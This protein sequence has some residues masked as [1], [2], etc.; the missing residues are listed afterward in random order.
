MNGDGTRHLGLFGATTVGVG[1]IVGGGIL[2]LAGIAFATAGPAALLAFALNGGI[3]LL[4]A[5]SFAE[6]AVRFPQSGGTYTYAKRV[7]SIEAAF[8]VG[9]VAW[10]ASIVAGVLYALGFAAFASEGAMHLLRRLGHE[11]AW[12]EGAQLRAVLAVSATAWYALAL[13]RSARG[14]GN[15][16]TVG[17][18]VVFAVL[19]AGGLWVALGTPARTLLSHLDPFLP[20]G[21]LGLVQAMGYSFIALQGFD[22]IAAVGGEVRDPQR[23]LPRAMYLSLAI[24]LAVYLPLL[25]VLATVGAPE[26]GSILDAASA[27]PAGLVAEAAERFLGATG[28]WL[29]IGAG[30][31]SM[32]SA[33]QANLLGASRVAFAMAR[34]RTLPR[35]LGR[36]RGASGTPALAVAVT[37]AMLGSLAVAVDDVPAAGAASSLVFLITFAMVH[38]AAIL[39]RRRS[40]QP[41]IPPL[42]VAGGVLC[43][44][45]AFFQAFAVPTAGIIV[46]SWLIVGGLFYFT[47]LAPGASLAD[48]SAEARDPDLARLR[49]R[50]PLVLVP[51]A[52]P[53]SAASLAGVAATVRTPGVGRV[54]L[55]SVVAELDEEP[56]E[57][58][59][60]L[61]DAQVILGES[62][63]R[64]FER[65]APAETLFTVAADSAREIVR[66]A[67]LHRCETVVMGAPKLREP[68]VEAWLEDLIARL[69]ADVVVVRA[70][71]RWR[72]DEVRRVLVPIGGTRDHSRLRARLLASLSRTEACT[73]T[74]LRAVAPSDSVGER[75][76][77]ERELRELARDECEGHYEVIVEAAADPQAAILA[78]AAETDLVLMGLRRDLLAGDAIGRLALA[79]AAGSEV[80]LI[81]IGSRRGRAVRRAPMPASAGHA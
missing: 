43:L 70:P 36:M 26:G 58:H 18:L 49:G 20:R 14:G 17:K 34:D 46:F 16:A 63:R 11:A 80:P 71:H 12:I 41:G 53:D 59:P 9:W 64:S 37:A 25:F 55:F 27:N 40:G 72:V 51:V 60:A 78:H 35:P 61:H 2:A 47:L 15:T 24:A 29:V 8:V 65:A 42:P 31:L 75:R 22:L 52:N 62:L 48:I 77:V 39:A 66:V 23:N 50:S 67:R 81:L 73:I 5:A 30:V 3:A 1:A 13:T 56:G 79:V 4:T 38:W 6:L 68:N 76:R 69:S 10:F 45:L 57:D 28:F 54:L 74:F 7:L 19:I 32:L 21:P 44:S 33:L